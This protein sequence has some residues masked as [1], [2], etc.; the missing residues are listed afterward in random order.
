LRITKKVEQER[1]TPSSLMVFE[2]D[3]AFL[4][5][6]FGEHSTIGNV[7][8]RTVSAHSLIYQKRQKESSTVLQKKYWF[9]LLML[10]FSITACNPVVREPAVTPGDD[11][12]EQVGAEAASAARLAL[13][14]H[15]GVSADLVEL[16]QMEETE[17]LDSCLGLGG[18]AESCATGSTPGYTLTFT[19]DG[20][21]YAVRTNLDGSEARVEPAAEE[22]ESLP[23]VVTAAQAEL[24]RQLGVEPDTIAVFSYTEMAWSDSC[25]GLGGPAESCAAENT[26]GWQ[27]MLGV[28]DA[29]Y[30]V[31]TD[32]TGQQV[33]VAD[34]SANTPAADIPGPE[35]QGAVVFFER[36]GGLAGEL[37]TV[38]I[39]PDGT[40]ERAM[41]EPAPDMPVKTAMIDPATVAALV[42]DL[43]AA[44]Y[45]DLE[46]TYLPADLCC[47]RLLYLV[48][49]QGEEE[50]QTVE[51]LEA[52]PE[53]PDALWQ[54]VALI[55]EVIAEV[56]AE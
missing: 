46:R 2:V 22:P 23:P 27:V 30:E 4:P 32:E 13:A 41:G 16:E 50:V 54:S 51:A 37:L 21:R 49:V 17:W 11:S 56:F 15:L 25:L 33:R 43:E 39:Y 19:V 5:I 55:E 24:A 35:L 36:S 20:E 10:L 40:V 31:R 9:I 53:T 47:D 6:L 38:R 14:S 28:G 7:L 44:G 3:P 26:P 48:S 8:S 45:F 42:T 34:E 12:A 29:V 1:N 52:T 18:P